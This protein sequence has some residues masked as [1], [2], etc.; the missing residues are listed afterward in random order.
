MGK[1]IAILMLV[2]LIA[3][4]ITTLFFLSSHAKLAFDPQPKNI[5]VSTPVSVRVSDPHGLRRF[6]AAIEQNGASTTL[7]ETNQPADRMKFWLAQVPAQEI[8]FNAG[9]KPSELA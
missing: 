8:R 9:S 6:S 7:F 1:I 3:T 5:G 4:P 2:A